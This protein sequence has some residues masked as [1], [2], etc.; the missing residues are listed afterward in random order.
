MYNINI[1]V[2]FVYIFLEPYKIK[3]EDTKG[4]TEAVNRRR[5]KNTITIRI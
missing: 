3:F 5:T 4:V 2:L 1:V